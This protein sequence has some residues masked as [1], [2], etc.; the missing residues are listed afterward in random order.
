MTQILKALAK[1]KQQKKQSRSQETGRGKCLLTKRGHR[2]KMVKVL[3][4]CWSHCSVLLD[5]HYCFKKE[6]IA[7][8]GQQKGESVC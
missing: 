2:R 5:F 7:I 1:L 4:K 6:G 3:V 8:E